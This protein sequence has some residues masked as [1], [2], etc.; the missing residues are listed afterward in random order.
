MGLGLFTTIQAQVYF[1]ETFDTG[2]PSTWQNIDNTTNGGGVWE[3]MSNQGDGI[4]LFDSDTY[5]NDGKAENADLISPAFDC[6]AATDVYLNIDGFFQQYQS[7]A[8]KIFVSNNDGATWTLM[9]TINTTS[10]AVYLNISSI[11]AGQASV[12][13]KFNYT[14]NWD[15]YW[16]ID[17]IK[18]YTPDA[19]DASILSI[20]N[21]EFLDIATGANFK[22]TIQGL[23]LSPI[24]SFDL[25]YSVDGGALVTQSITGVNI[26]I[27]TT[28][29]YTHSSTWIPSS[30]GS[31]NVT[32]SVSNVNA[33]TDAD[34]SNNSV[35]KSFKVYSMELPA[36]AVRR[37][38]LYEVFT[39]STCG[40]CKPGN[41]N[42]HNIVD[43]KPQDEFVAVKFQQDFPG[44]GDPYTTV[45]TVNRRNFYNINSIPR[46]EIDGGWDENANDFTEN[47]Y[48]YSRSIPSYMDLSAIY[49][50]DVATKKV[51]ITVSG[52]S[53][54]DFPTGNYKLQTSILE[55][56]TIDNKKS[57]GETKFYNV[58][59]KMLPDEKG[60]AIAALSLN[61]EINEAL[62]YTFNGD[63]RLPT[64][65]TAANRIK[66][67]T[68]HTV[69]EF[70]DLAVVVWV[71]NYSTK[72]VLQAAHA[73]VDT[74]NDGYSDEEEIAAG[75]N[76]NDPLSDP[77]T[78]GGNP[79]VNINDVNLVKAFS[80][81]PNPATDKFNV[82]ISIAN[83]ET[84]SIELINVL[85][86]TLKTINT[87]T[88]AEFNTN[89][90]AK[91]VYFVKV[92]SNSKVVAT[93]PVVIK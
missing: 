50:V 64:N 2:I 92:I 15:Y 44:T 8:G 72:T 67:P 42:F 78:V 75:S 7:S 81:Y 55:N 53:L 12:K 70:T 63:Y 33:G 77:T 17:A 29:T 74:D 59:K 28:Y 51:S 62:E 40:P 61:T 9:K 73:K 13:L 49:H 19:I 93:T 86:E 88:N 27:G 21:D 89:N 84:V 11:A 54:Q 90:L 58:V 32:V 5:G 57:N 35:S 39:S 41:E 65:G 76:P 16:V 56:T 20:N 30:V 85:G 79:G 31:K 48:K 26:P 24:T 1:E 3:W 4:V 83:N 43:S 10:G 80:V 23:G 71:E 14:G 82:A 91:G 6:T 87:N 36:G 52:K 60:T 46:M 34:M 38:P 47:L 25:N 68:E 45:E 18:V 37:V 22:G 69:E 66:L